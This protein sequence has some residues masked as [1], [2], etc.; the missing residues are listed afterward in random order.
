MQW[1]RNLTRLKLFSQ[2]NFV[3]QFRENTRKGKAS[4]AAYLSCL[5][6]FQEKAEGK[7]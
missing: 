2:R 7:R 5:N 6:Q 1:N 3:A 4:L